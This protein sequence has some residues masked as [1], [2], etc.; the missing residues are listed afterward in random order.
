M[1]KIRDGGAFAK[2]FRIGDD[3]EFHLA[4]FGIGGKGAAEFEA[5]ARGDGAFFD[6]EFGRFRFRDDLPGYVV[7][8]RKVALAGILV[9]GSHT[10][11][12]SVPG[13][14]GFTA[15]GGKGDPT[16][17]GGRRENLVE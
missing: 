1:E 11:E 10:D 6:D 3:A 13:T 14:D 17:L 16:G 2:K 9:R 12:D 5:G 8:G 7:E 15:D 4:I